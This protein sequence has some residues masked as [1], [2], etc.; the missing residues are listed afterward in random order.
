MEDYATEVAYDVCDALGMNKTDLEE[1][2]E[3][4]DS[5]N[6]VNDNAERVKRLEAGLRMIAKGHTAPKTLAWVVLDS[7]NWEPP[8]VID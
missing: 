4:L 2:Q 5:A 7:P 6:S 8:E 3:I 1:L